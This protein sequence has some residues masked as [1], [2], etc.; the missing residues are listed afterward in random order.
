MIDLKN[1]SVEKDN[2]IILDN[3]S[4]TIS[5]GDKLLIK[6]ESGS[7]KTTLI[8]TILFFENFTGKIFFENSE[9]TTKS[10]CT[11]RNN[12]SYISQ[13]TIASDKSVKDFLLYPLSY[14]INEN[15]Q[16]KNILNKID[17]YLQDFSLTSAILNKCFKN[18]SGGEKQRLILI[19]SLLLNKQNLI[20]DEIT[21]ALDFDNRTKIIETLCKI[22]DLTLI[23]VSHNIEW[24]KYASKIVELKK[25]K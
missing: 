3:F 5:R 18:L 8:K 9:V 6:G 11:Y 1:I 22:E 2:Q 24:E 16:R 4:L 21:S 12:F 14:K 15:M 20:L 10:I 17:R 7:G 25:C 13:K 23:I 19:Q